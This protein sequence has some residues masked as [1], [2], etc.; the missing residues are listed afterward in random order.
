MFRGAF[1]SLLRHATCKP[2]CVDVAACDRRTSCPYAQIFKPVSYSGPSGLVDSPRPFVLRTR[3]LDGRL[4]QPAEPFHVDVHLFTLAYQIADH[5]REVF[6][7]FEKVG[8]GPQRS[9]ATLEI[10][11]GPTTLA[12]PLTQFSPGVAA[13]RVEFSSP[14]ELKQRGLVVEQPMFHALWSRACDRITM[15]RAIYG[16]GPLAVDF[17]DLRNLAQ[18]VS[19]ARHRWLPVQK[20]RRSSRTGQVHPLGGFLGFAEYEGQ[21]G[22]FLPYLQAA[23][24]TGIGRQTVWGKGEIA[25]RSSTVSTQP[26]KTS[27]APQ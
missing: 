3:H 25:I 10:I 16:D 9:R 23:Q 17:R 19:L 7:Q 6:S 8:F 4:L 18:Q 1:G 22:P 15:L 13:I 24:W 12:L 14:T 11:T 26:L 27:T 20:Q 21:L 5:F 2:P